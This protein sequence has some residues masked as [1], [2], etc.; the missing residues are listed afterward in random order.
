M[1]NGLKEVRLGCGETFGSLLPSGEYPAK[2]HA[3]LAEGGDGRGIE[4][5]ELAGDLLVPGVL[6]LTSS[7]REMWIISQQV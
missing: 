2:R 3:G 7:W 1:A 5:T 6:E 4:W